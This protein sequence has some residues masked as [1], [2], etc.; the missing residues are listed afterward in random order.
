MLFYFAPMEG[1]TSYIYRRVH[2]QM[3]P[4]AARYFSPFISPDSAGKYRAGSLRNL[5]PENNAGLS[6][7]PQLLCN[8]AEPFLAAARELQAMGYN[9]VNLNAGCPSATVVPKHKGAGML[10]D[11]RS[12]DDFLADVFSRCPVA[13]SV[14]TRLGVESTEEFPAILEIYNKYPLS[15]LIIHARDRSG[16]YKSRPDLPAF[17]SA[18]E[19]SRAAVCYNGDIFS[20]A[21]LAA[22]T[23]AAPALD[24][25]MVGRGA[26]ANPA[27]IRELSG[28]APLG[29]EELREFLAELLRAF[30]EAGLGE[31]YT[32]AR[33]KELWYYTADMFPDCQRYVKHINKSQ[34]L[35]DYTAAVEALFASG[36][37]SASGVFR[38]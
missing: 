18:M 12:L 7:V 24:R 15:E 8:R 23:E 29:R 30:S 9:E 34:H 6:L 33:L 31:K 20:P 17:L 1:V 4:G 19:H 2:A 38:G 11:L 25:V 16:M 27:L 36:G 32:L 13:V 28:G 35:P 21:A 14:K 26:A 10:L 3:F 22:L 37:F 5:R